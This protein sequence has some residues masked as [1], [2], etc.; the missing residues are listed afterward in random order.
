MLDCFQATKRYTLGVL[1]AIF[2]GENPNEVLIGQ[3]GGIQTTC[4]PSGQIPDPTGY[5]HSLIS[6]CTSLPRVSKTRK[7]R[8]VREVVLLRIIQQ[9]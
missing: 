8:F 7:I 4:N 2:S 5:S 6:V 1:I 3:L 9:I